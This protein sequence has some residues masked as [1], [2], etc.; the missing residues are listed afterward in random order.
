MSKT[1]TDTN[2]QINHLP[3]ELDP[4]VV[5]FLNRERIPITF[6]GVRASFWNGRIVIEA[7]PDLVRR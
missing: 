2:N 6:R 5:E 4:Q 7:H 1:T 3:C